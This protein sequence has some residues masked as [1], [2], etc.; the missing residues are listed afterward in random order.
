MIG[1]EVVYEPCLISKSESKSKKELDVEDCPV[2]VY[3]IVLNNRRR[4]IP[5]EN[6]ITNE[7]E[8]KFV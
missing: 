4:N 2:N 8:R 1:D 6:I 3:G 5:K 7:D